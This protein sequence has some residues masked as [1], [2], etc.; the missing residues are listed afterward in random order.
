MADETRRD[1]GVLAEINITPLIDVMLVLLIIF[2]L[3]APVANRGLDV[4]LPQERRQAEAP[5]PAP[6]PVVM[7]L[8]GGRE[9]RLL[10]SLNQ[11]P[12]DTSELGSRL[13]DVFQAQSD[14]TLFVR[15]EGSVR[16]GQ[17]VE[18]MDTAR[19]AGVARIGI[20]GAEPVR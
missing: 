19:G 14:K 12:V 11:R 18:A 10:V 8:E 20:L 2:M 1:R 17:V 15:A 9:G 7:T 13:R 3:V 16:Y 4:G 6:R 5:V